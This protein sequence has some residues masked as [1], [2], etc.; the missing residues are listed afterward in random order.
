LISKYKKNPLTHNGIDIDEYILLT[1]YP[2][3]IIFGLG[4]S[5]KKKK[6]R[7]STTYLF[8]AAKGI[9]FSIA[10]FF[11]VPNGGATGLAIVLALFA[12]LLLFVARKYI[13]HPEGGRE[14]QTA[15]NSKV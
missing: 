3:I 12:I 8:Q 7:Q 2:T 11:V 5:G 13:V 6:L 15:A 1:L 10:Y 4:F 9:I 14:S